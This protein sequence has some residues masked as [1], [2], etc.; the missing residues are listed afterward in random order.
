VRILVFY[1]ILSVCSYRDNF[2]FSIFPITISRRIVFM[3]QRANFVSSCIFARACDLTGTES[4]VDRVRILVFY[5][6]LSIC[7][8]RDN[9]RF[10]IIPLSDNH[11][12]MNRVYVLTCQLISISR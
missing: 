12:E 8:C 11:F 10:L 1:E 2:R 5:D 7:S 3:C 9:F 6:T 4:R